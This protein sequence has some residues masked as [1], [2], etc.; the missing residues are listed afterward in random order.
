M[1]ITPCPGFSSKTANLSN[2]SNLLLIFADP[3]QRAKYKA[4]SEAAMDK[5]THL[6]ALRVHSRITYLVSLLPI[7][8][9]E[10]QEPLHCT[11]FLPWGDWGARVIR[12][13]SESRR[14]SPLASTESSCSSAYSCHGNLPPFQLQASEYS[15]AHHLRA[16]ILLP[17]LTPMV[18]QEL[19]MIALYVVSQR[20][21]CCWCADPA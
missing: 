8:F 7:D 12:H 20:Y 13:Q 2:L 15:L 6:P 5:L 4:D 19:N 14:H 11:L 16:D 9:S 3:A 18:N 17:Y 10:P 21:Y 1:P